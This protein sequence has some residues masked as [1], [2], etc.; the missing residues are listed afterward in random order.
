MYSNFTSYWLSIAL[1]FS[2]FSFIVLISENSAIIRQPAL[3]IFH[4]SSYM[5]IHQGQHKRFQNHYTPKFSISWFYQLSVFSPWIRICIM[6]SELLRVDCYISHLI[7][8]ISG[9]VLPYIRT[10]S[11]NKLWAIRGVFTNLNNYVAV[12]LNL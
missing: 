7:E 1:L 8:H 11:F 2:Q 12:L 4:L 10:S 6:N 5:L 9:L 3:N